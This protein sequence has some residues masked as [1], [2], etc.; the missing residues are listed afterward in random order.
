[1]LTVVRGLGS[2]RRRPDDGFTV[3]ELGVAM[4]VSALLLAMVVTAL[5]SLVGAYRTVQDTTLSDDRGRVIL[6][7]ID[8]DLRQASAVN[9]PQTVGAAAF[10]EYE[11]DVGPPGA[12]PT[13]TQWR[14]D[15]ST[16]ELAVRTWTLPAPAVA[17]SWGTIASGV[18]NDLT[19]EPPFAV[20][21]STPGASVQRE[22][23]TVQ[24]RL[25]LPKGDALTRA[26][27]TARNSS[28][29]GGAVT[30]ADGDGVPDA[31]VCLTFGRS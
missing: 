29:N 2:T 5:L 12:P 1:V 25:A 23:L 27:V 6:D 15:G 7:R 8:R 16:H 30:D 11:T 17:P 28:A 18:V 24:L 9:L 10:V 4:I 13:C 21:G 31:P 3:V 26:T 20:A 19:A 14:L 22:Q